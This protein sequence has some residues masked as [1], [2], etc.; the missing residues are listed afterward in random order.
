MNTLKLV[1]LEET[2]L[3]QNVVRLLLFFKFNKNLELIFK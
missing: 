2:V 1:Q 3:T